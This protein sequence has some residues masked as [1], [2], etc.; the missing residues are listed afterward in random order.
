MVAVAARQRQFIFH[1]RRGAA[2]Q[3]QFIFYNRR[4]SFQKKKVLKTREFTE[5]FHFK[6]RYTVKLDEFHRLE[7][8]ALVLIS[9]RLENLEISKVTAAA[10][11][12]FTFF[13]Y[14]RGAAAAR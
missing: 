1:Y 8:I 13:Y 2:R 9:H 5:N 6:E 4:G 11:A 3:R 7:T 12:R 14:R 10:A